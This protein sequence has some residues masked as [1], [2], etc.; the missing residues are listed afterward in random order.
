[1]LKNYTCKAKLPSVDSHRLLPILHLFMKL[2]WSQRLKDDKVLSKYSMQSGSTIHALKKT[3]S[4][5]QVQ[6]KDPLDSIS[7]QQQT[8]K[9]KCK[10]TS[11]KISLIINGGPPDEI[12]YGCK[13]D[14]FVLNICENWLSSGHYSS[15]IEDSS[16]KSKQSLPK[17]TWYLRGL[18][19]DHWCI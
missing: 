10:A 16:C 2:Y 7:I 12:D 15:H 9:S 11:G 17:N 6:V 1:M 19:K 4:E 3:V 8:G 18:Q 5:N 14:N 13:E